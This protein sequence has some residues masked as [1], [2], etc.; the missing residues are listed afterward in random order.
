MK[1]STNWLELKKNGCARPSVWRLGCINRLNPACGKNKPSSRTKYLLTFLEQMDKD[2]D[3][4]IIDY[5]RFFKKKQSFLLYKST[6]KYRPIPASTYKE[7][8]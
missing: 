2:D 4:T 6:C 3:K 1:K 8:K 5:N 7:Q